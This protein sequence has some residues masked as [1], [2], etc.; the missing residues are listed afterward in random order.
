MARQDLVVANSYFPASDV[1]LLLGDGNGGFGAAKHFPVGRQPT[2]VVADGDFNGDQN[3]DFATANSDRPS[4]SAPGTVSVRLGDGKGDFGPVTNFPTGFV[5]S[6]L[7]TGDFNNDGK[8]DLSVGYEGS[9]VINESPFIVNPGGVSVWLGNGTGGF[10][11]SHT[12][13]FGQSA[14]KSIAAGDLN[15]DGNLDLAQDSSLRLF[16]QDSRGVC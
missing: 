10:T 1:S 4:S 15:G 7:A 11:Q 2:F 12:S 14:V 6:S 16:R 13:E 5:P 8:L 3:L 9:T